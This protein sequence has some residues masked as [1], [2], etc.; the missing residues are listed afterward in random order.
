MTNSATNSRV[1][2]FPFPVSFLCPHHWLPQRTCPLKFSLRTLQVCIFLLK[3]FLPLAMWSQGHSQTLGFHYCSC[4]LPNTKISFIYRCS[5]SCNFL[6]RA[7]RVSPGNGCWLPPHRSNNLQI[8]CYQSCFVL[9]LDRIESRSPGH[10]GLCFWRD[11][12]QR[13]CRQFKTTTLAVQDPM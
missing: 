12:C 11:N 8:P 7:L 2:P 4:P 10:F 9:L 5:L 1:P 3:V 13:I 6:H